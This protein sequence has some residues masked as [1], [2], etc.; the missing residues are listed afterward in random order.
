MHH[1]KRSSL[2]MAILTK[3]P[4]LTNA[5]DIKSLSRNSF[6]FNLKQKIINKYFNQLAAYFQDLPL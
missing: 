4:I 2:V 5:L 3:L 1:F 6:F